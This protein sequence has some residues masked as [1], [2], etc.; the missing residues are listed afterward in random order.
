MNLLSSSPFLFSCSAA[1]QIS[2]G[3][4]SPKNIEQV[5]KLNM[6]IFPVKYNDKF[7]NDLANNA[8]GQHPYT[9]LAY[10][11]DIMVGAIACR[12]EP[13]ENSS[14]FKVYVMT[15]GVLAPYRR[16]GIG[17]KLLEQTLEACAK[18]GPDLEEVYLHV[19]VGNDD[20]VNFYKGFGFE[21]GEIVKDY[22]QRLDP[23]DAYVISKKRE[24]FAPCAA[25]CTA[26]QRHPLRGLPLL[27]PPGHTPP[28]GSL[29]EHG[30]PTC[31]PRSS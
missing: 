26:R 25:P 27:G 15:I 6:A 7:Y 17:A 30:L 9:F 3:D 16:L 29:P 22:Y 20:A 5:R 13:Q 11:A 12:V 23:N 1:A 14:G 18:A 2:F 8:M 21:K 31:L 19:Q 10:F 24:C 28:H 4:V